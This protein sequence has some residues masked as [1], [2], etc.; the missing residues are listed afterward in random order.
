MKSLMMKFTSS[1]SLGLSV[2]LL[3]ISAVANYSASMLL[4][5]EEIMIEWEAI[6]L[7]ST[8][9]SLVII[10]DFMSLY[11][12]S[13]VSL[14]AGSVMI[15]S[16]SYMS[17][18]RFFGRFLWLVLSFILSMYALILSPN[19]ISLML[20]WDGLGVTSYLLVV[21]Y[22]SSKSYTA[23][24]VTALTNRLGDVGLLITIAMALPLGSWSLPIY[25]DSSLVVANSLMGTI[26]LS[27]C[28]KSAQIPF[29]AWL[30]AAMAAP[31]PVS[32]L[33]HSSTLVTAGVYLL[34][35]MNALLIKFSL[36]EVLMFLGALTMLVAGGAAILEMDMKKII[37]LST[38]SQLGIMMMTLGAGAPTLAYFHLLSHA[39]FKAMLFMCAGMVIHNMSDYQDIRKMGLGWYSLPVVSSFISVANMS[40][41]GLPFLSGFYSK[42][43][44][45]EMMIMRGP[46][47]ALLLIISIG[48]FLTVAYSCRLSFLVSLNM[49]KSETYYHAAEGD[50]M[51][52]MG[53]ALL[54]L[55]SLGGGMYLNWNLFSAPSLVFLP[56]WLKVLVLCV[57]IL[58]IYTMSGVFKDVSSGTSSA[59]K[60]FTSSM[61]YMPLTFSPSAIDNLTTYSKS[62]FKVVEV[63][64]SETILFKQAF[65]LFYLN[66][67]SKYLDHVPQLYVMQTVK[68]FMVVLGGVLMF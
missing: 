55:F 12:V 46:G 65:N 35:R 36:L 9:I 42:D 44:I 11:F 62:T 5:L 6:S 21:F 48:T 60:L 49:S 66:S 53:M 57:I 33:V 51:M 4:S 59:L 26:I 43:I 47:L 37:A 34:I 10:I 64:W 30:P 52:L 15:F 23:G 25:S 16:T 13:L 8:T 41:C 32:A 39:F 67:F 27:A 14:V 7:S 68:I 18:E 1:I 24:M 38:L 20:G 54:F 50:K 31:T 19:L 28:T 63:T 40:L 61:W 17:A 56:F 2:S 45:L 22:Q 29:S 3:T 58:A